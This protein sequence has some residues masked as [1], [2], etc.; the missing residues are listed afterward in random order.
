MMN[1]FDE[2]KSLSLQSEQF[3]MLAINRGR[4]IKK[5]EN[6]KLFYEFC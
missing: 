1:Y 5:A 3:K 2:N 6:K 4:I